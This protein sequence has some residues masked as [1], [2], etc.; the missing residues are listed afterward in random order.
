MTLRGGLPWP[1]VPRC[2]GTLAP[3]AKGLTHA[4]ING[5]ELLH[6]GEDTCPFGAC[7]CCRYKLWA[8]KAVPAALRVLRESVLPG[9]M[10]HEVRKLCVPKDVLAA[11]NSVP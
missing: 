3:P 6:F 9:R 4:S 5:A 2:A 10:P 11:V 7:L 1:L 8:R